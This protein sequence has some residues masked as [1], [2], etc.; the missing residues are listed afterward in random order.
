[1]HGLDLVEYCTIGAASKRK[2]CSLVAV[3][4]KPLEKGDRDR[5][6]PCLPNLK[7]VRLDFVPPTA[8]LSFMPA[9]KVVS[10]VRAARFPDH[11]AP[12][13]LDAETV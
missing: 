2:K 11:H 5:D 13:A 3:Y 10:L 8:D 9:D 6:A 7:T 1:M 12:T 4:V